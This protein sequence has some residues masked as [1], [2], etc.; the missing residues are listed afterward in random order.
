MSD[1]STFE[2]WLEVRVSG[3]PACTIF[4]RIEMAVRPLVGERISFMQDKGS[5]LEFQVE[6][7]D[8]GWRR[9]S[10]V[11]VE[12]D[13]IS[14]YAV[15]SKQGIEF[16]ALVRAAPLNVRAA[17]D[18]RAVRDILTKQLGFEVDPYGVNTLEA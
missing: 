10:T 9:D 13:E 6:W 17:D 1:M 18:A 8:V 16:T 3:Q 15:R 7:P 12:V 11:S 2:F 14:H 5:A 4:G